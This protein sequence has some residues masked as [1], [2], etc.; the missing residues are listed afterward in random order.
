[1]NK[2]VTISLIL[3]F[4]HTAGIA[5]SE[6]VYKVNFTN[7]NGTS[8]LLS[9]PT[10]F[11]SPRAILKKNR[12]QIDIDSLDLPV[13]SLYV[14][15]IVDMTAAG[16]HGT[17]RWLNAAYFITPDTNFI[18]A[19]DTLDYVSSIEK[20]A[21]YPLGYGDILPEEASEW[22]EEPDHAN[23]QYDYG[24]AVQ[25]MNMHNAQRLHINDYTGNNAMIAILD[26]G[27]ED[28]NIIQSLGHVFTTGRLKGTHN[29]VRPALDIYSTGSHGTKMMSILASLDSSVLVGT[30]PDAEYVLLVTEDRRSE[31]LIEIENYVMGIEFSDSM[32]VD[33][34]TSSIGY[35][36]FDDFNDNYSLSELDGKTC[37]ASIAATIGARKGLIIVTSVGNEADGFWDHILFPADADSILSVGGVDANGI[38]AMES[39]EGPTADG[40]IKPDVVSQGIGVYAYGRG[41]VLT[42][43]KGTSF[44]VPIIAGLTACFMQMD[45]NL[46]PQTYVNLIREY[47]NHFSN[48]RNDIGF[49]IPNFGSL[50]NLLDVP[51]HILDEKI[52][53]IYPNPSHNRLITIENLSNL[54][55]KSM[56]LLDA[57]GKVL[58][59]IIWDTHADRFMFSSPT[60]PGHY[61][62][63]LKTATGIIPKNLI[64][65]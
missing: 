38:W 3:F 44:A 17:S 15:E 29:F 34:V 9:D 16:I 61:T 8:H 32:G 11:L 47:S 13:S 14:D 24:N 50:Y 40:R 27:F 35:N 58:D 45:T 23:K 46:H 22:D 59:E 49:G 5:Q 7:K 64:I 30:A 62:L 39:G 25:V 57:T 52:V 36:T 60:T 4:C 33:V 51:L 43:N 53:H 1:M 63:L 41:D 54:K 31:K 6:Y 28:V 56:L 42:V 21:F 18:S 10:T 55:I 26:N 48:P 20:I 37:P 12:H 65:Y 19:V 2:L